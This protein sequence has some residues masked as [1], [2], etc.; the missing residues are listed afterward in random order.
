MNR[1]TDSVDLFDPSADACDRPSGSRC[2]LLPGGRGGVSCDGESERTY[3]PVSLNG[4]WSIIGDRE[5]PSWNTGIPLSGRI[6]VPTANF[7]FGLLA[8]MPAESLYETSPESVV[9]MVSRGSEY[10]SP[11]NWMTGGSFR[12]EILEKP[13]SPAPVPAVDGGV[14][15]RGVDLRSPVRAAKAAGTANGVDRGR[16][17]IVEPPPPA[18]PERDAERAPT[19]PRAAPPSSTCCVRRR[20]HRRSAN[21][22]NKSMARPARP[23][24]TLP[25]TVAAGGDEESLGAGDAGLATGGL[26]SPTVKPP[27]VGKMEPPSD[28]VEVPVTEGDRVE[29]MTENEIVVEPV[30][31]GEEVKTAGKVAVELAKASGELVL[32]LEGSS[33]AIADAVEFV[34]L[35]ND[36]KRGP[37]EEGVDV[38]GGA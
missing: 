3:G 12:P 31:S 34:T 37:P 16:S 1:D 27:A 30:A 25:A 19:P 13:R 28:E 17:D 32:L 21:A 14:S 2:C 6:G 29:E 22:K 33:G 18:G 24:I 23:P 15:G 35:P 4:P 36:G 20:L 10:P 38:T 26:P 11:P 9:I 7:W 5:G 8:N